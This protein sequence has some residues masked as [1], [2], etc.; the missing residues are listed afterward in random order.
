MINDI[1][2]IFAGIGMLIAVYLVATNYSGLN[3]LLNSFIGG[4]AA[5]TALLQGRSGTIPVGQGSF[6]TANLKLNG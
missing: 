1:M 3:T 2:K 5:E 6:N 4:T